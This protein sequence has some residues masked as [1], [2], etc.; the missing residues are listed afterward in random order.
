MNIQYKKSHFN[1]LNDLKCLE[2]DMIMNDIHNLYIY[3]TI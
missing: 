1:F 2:N 3:I